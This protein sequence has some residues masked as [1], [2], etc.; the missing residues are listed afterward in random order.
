MYIVHILRAVG[1]YLVSTYG[2]SCTVINYYPEYQRY[3]NSYVISIPELVIAKRNEYNIS[4][5]IGN[6]ILIVYY[7]KPIFKV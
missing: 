3:K 7:T 4:V 6:A 5:G 1:Q 2:F